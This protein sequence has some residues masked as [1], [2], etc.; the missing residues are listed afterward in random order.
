MK[1]YCLEYQQFMQHKEHNEESKYESA[2]REHVPGNPL[3]TGK[4]IYA[5]QAAQNVEL[6]IFE[7]VNLREKQQDGKYAREKILSDTYCPPVGTHVC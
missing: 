1:H 4:Q 3:I 6:Y 5:R 2:Y 7:I